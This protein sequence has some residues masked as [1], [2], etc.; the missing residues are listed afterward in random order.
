MNLSGK[1]ASWDLLGNKAGKTVI[2]GEAARSLAISSDGLAIFVVNYKSNTI[3][4]VRTIDMKVL[5]SIKTC[6][7][8]IGV[9]YDAPSGNIWVACYKGEIRVYSNS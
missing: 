4:K 8:P 1:V 2:T 5:E 9:T 3:S 6:N 7:Q